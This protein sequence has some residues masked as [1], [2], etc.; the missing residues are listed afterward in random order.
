MLQDEVRAD[1]ERLSG[2]NFLLCNP[3]YSPSETTVIFYSKQTLQSDFQTVIL[4]GI[5][6]SEMNCKVVV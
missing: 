6:W 4:T 5:F 3:R 1:M 2:A